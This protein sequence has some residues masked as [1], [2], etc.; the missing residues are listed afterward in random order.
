[1]KFF[2]LFIFLFCQIS[3]GYSQAFES[4]PLPIII[5]QTDLVN[6]QPVEI[7]DDPKVLADMTIIFRKDG[8]R[9]YLSDIN[10]SV[11]HEYNGRIGIEIRGSSSQVLPKKPYGLTTYQSDNVTNNNVE[12]FGFPKENDW[13]LNALAFDPSLIRDYLSYELASEMGNYASHGRYCELVI[14]GDYKGLYVFMEKLKIDEGR[15]DIEKMDETNISGK[16]LTGGFI[17][18]ADKTTGG[19]PVA[20]TLGFTNY[21][22]ESP[23]PKDI[24]TEQHAYIKS[25]FYKLADRTRAKDETIETGYA[26]LIDVPSFVDFMLISE[27]ASNADSYQ[28]STFFH[29]ERGGKL[30]AGPVWDYNLTFGNDLFLWGY[31]RSFTNVWQFQFENS[32]S[33]FWK[34]LYYLPS[35]KC[36]LSQRW[37]ELTSE[38][39][40]WSKQRIYNKIDSLVTVIS[41]AKDREEQRWNSVGNHQESID[42][43]KSWINDRFIWINNEFRGLTCEQTIDSPKLVITEINYNPLDTP[44][45]ESKQLEFIGITNAENKSISLTGIHIKQLGL[46]YQF[47]LNSTLEAGE[48]IYLASDSLA[49]EKQYGITPFGEYFRRLSNASYPIVLA[50]AFG[51][52]IDSVRYFDS[53]PWPFE[54]DGDGFY[55]SLIDLNSDNSLAENWKLSSTM[56]NSLA[57]NNAT[58]SSDGIQIYPN[59]SP[60]FIT[61]RHKSS[62]IESY[63][64]YDILGREVSTLRQIKANQH[65]I[66]LQNLISGVY[67]IR[68]QFANSLAVTQK[69]VKIR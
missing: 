56:T 59:P 5:I 28:F 9:N 21:I 23:K 29:K 11:H 25:I 41:E 16:E 17:T 49:F 33:K 55:L 24:R 32:G 57:E 69:I 3:F 62:L 51:E 46:S 13:I 20:W 35:F 61:L 66:S 39:G 43:M 64:I 67:F 44:E 15:I 40:I 19:D 58:S 42:L 10:N 30:R 54:A 45:F 4:S 47:P 6:G 2:L 36:R 37:L 31:D 22:H 68:V 27:L 26:S 60:Q 18:K 8:S 52:H 14:N 7:P 38:N 12:I 1:M 48:F 53:T 63:T 50:N 65:R 34:E